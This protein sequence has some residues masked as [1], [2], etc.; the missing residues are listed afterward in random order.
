MS[1][2]DFHQGLGYQWG[3]WRPVKRDGQR[4][5]RFTC[6]GCGFDALLVDTHEIAP[7]GIVTPSLD[8]PNNGC[9]FHDNVRLVGWSP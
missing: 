5:V 4:T 9:G 6:P 1:T 7:D 3:S 2:R 8:C